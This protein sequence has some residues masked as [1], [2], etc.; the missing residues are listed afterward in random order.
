MIEAPNLFKR[1]DGDLWQSILSMSQP[2]TPSCRICR[3][4]AIVSFNIAINQ[5]FS[6]VPFCGRAGLY[7]PTQ[8]VI[9]APLDRFQLNFLW[10]EFNDLNL[11]GGDAGFDN[12]LSF[13]E[14]TDDASTN[15]MDTAWRMYV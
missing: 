6:P 2:M 13:L 3:P 1:Y 7:R 10:L 8:R 5:S 12:C 15:A 14:D 4:P 11:T 9:D